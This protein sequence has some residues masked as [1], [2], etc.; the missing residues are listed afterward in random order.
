MKVSLFVYDIIVYMK[1]PIDATKTLLNLINEF[2]K[3]AG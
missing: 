3:T 1:N 2:G